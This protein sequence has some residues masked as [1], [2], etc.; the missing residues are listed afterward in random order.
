MLRTRVGPPALVCLALGALGTA[1]VLAA[2]D[3]KAAVQAEL[4]KLAGTWKVQAVESNG[5]KGTDDELKGLRYVFKKDGKWELCKDDQ[6]LARG[7]FTIDPT[8]KPKTI[9]FKIEESTGEGAKG[10]KSLGIYELE[11][12]DLKVCRDWP[13]EGA[14]PTDLSAGAESKRILGEYK[15][16]KK[17]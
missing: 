13:G 12:N 1:G 11:G 6:T 4:K 7:T 8:M 2:E 9:D 3:K 5:R 14:R 10:K 16:A 15:R 17:P